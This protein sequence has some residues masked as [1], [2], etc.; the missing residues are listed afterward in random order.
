LLDRIRDRVIEV[1]DCW[2]WQGS[3][4]T[5]SP[6]PTMNYAGKVKP[7]RRHLAEEM[8]L[9]LDGKLATYKCGNQLCVHPDHI[10]VITRKR[11]QQRIA[12]EQ[13]HQLNPLRR[14]QLS[15]IARKNGKLTLEQ[16]HAIRDAEGPQRE[17]AKRFGVTQATVSV[18]K[19]GVSWRDYTNPFI[20][21][22]GGLK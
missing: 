16:A 5:N 10:A 8:G 3:L 2:E 13:K 17:I 22:F 18:I 9:K 21:L 6:V 15:D 11:L 14:K 7:V 12:K 1:G 19:R 20:Q 4:Q